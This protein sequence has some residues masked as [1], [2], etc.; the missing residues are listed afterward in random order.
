M[1]F[2]L[3]LNILFMVCLLGA[4]DANHVPIVELNFVCVPKYSFGLFYNNLETR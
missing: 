3:L 4:T 1:A 2:V